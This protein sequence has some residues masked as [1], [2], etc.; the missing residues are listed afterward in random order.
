MLWAYINLNLLVSFGTFD[1]NLKLWRPINKTYFY[2][3]YVS[4]SGYEEENIYAK[5]DDMTYYPVI[6]SQQTMPLPM[7][8]EAATLTKQH[9]IINNMMVTLP[10]AEQ[11]DSKTLNLHQANLQKQKDFNTFNAF[12]TVHRSQKI[13]L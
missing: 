5:V 6:S 2:L 12:S 10:H 1:I 4:R 11:I 9:N 8:G 7:G 13:Y 3:Y